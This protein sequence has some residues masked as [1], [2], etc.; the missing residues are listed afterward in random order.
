VK[1]GEPSGERR[2]RDRQ[3][4]LLAAGVVA[5]VLGLNVLSVMVP[6]VGDALGF[7]PLL[8]GVL[9]VATLIVLA[10]ALRPPSA[11]G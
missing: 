2:I 3:V 11:E 8:I 9:V 7:A 10:R 6:A 5:A 4:V 1:D